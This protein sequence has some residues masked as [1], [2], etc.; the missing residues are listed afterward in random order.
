LQTPQSPDSLLVQK[1]K[2]G[3]RG[4]FEILVMKYHRQVI[5]LCHR[6]TGERDTAE[7]LAQESFLKAYRAIGSFREDSSFYTWLYRIAVNVCLTYRSSQER[8][9]SEAA[10]RESDSDEGGPPL[11]FGASEQTP[12]KKVLQKEMGADIRRALEALPDE[13]RSAL[14]LREI[15]GL[16]YEEIAEILDVPAGTVK[17]RI[18][19]GREELKKKLAHHWRR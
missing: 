6:L 10:V 12:E 7:D 15:D 18:F 8:K 9:M 4:A 14:L 11:E 16:S 3:D 2:T 17:S 19:R 13:F 5:S 1:C